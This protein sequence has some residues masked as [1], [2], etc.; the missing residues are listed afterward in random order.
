VD[1][2]S[3]KLDIPP[4]TDEELRQFVDDALS[5][6]I[7]TSAQCSPD[8]I[9]MVFL[10]VVFGAFA[11]MSEEELEKVGVIYE[12]VEHRGPRSIN[13]LPQF[14]SFRILSRADWERV[15]PVLKAEVDRR[16]NVP[17]PKGV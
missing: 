15:I 13:G 4:A 3:K 5:G 14:F 16:K 2:E 17:I 12:R 7:F 8:E 9:R 6:R 1:E 10:P 11:G